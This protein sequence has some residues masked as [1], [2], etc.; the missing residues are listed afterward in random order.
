[1]YPL[2]L[3]T[4][5]RTGIVFAGT[6]ALTLMTGSVL[7]DGKISVGNAATAASAQLRVQVVIPK[8][9]GIRIGAANSAINTLPFSAT[10]EVDGNQV[11]GN[12]IPWGGGEGVVRLYPSGYPGFI[13]WG[14]SAAIYASGGDVTITSAGSNG[15]SLVSAE[16]NTIPLTVFRTYRYFG[17][18]DH[19]SS[20][21]GGSMT[22]SAPGNGVVNQTGGWAYVF[23]S[24]SA[25]VRP[26]GTFNTTI[27]YTASMP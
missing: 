24:A 15:D 16:G 2:Q 21:N 20:L 19:P 25:G 5:L 6:M 26:A 9:M 3:S 18:L 1:M 27:T 4:C 8:I 7:A 11:S 22:I 17:A 14:V 13:G 23:N 10:V 12:D